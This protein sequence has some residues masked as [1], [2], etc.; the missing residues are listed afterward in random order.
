VARIVSRRDLG[1]PGDVL[2][3]LP[4]STWDAA[5]VDKVREAVVHKNRLWFRYW[6]PTNWAFLAGDRTEQP[7]SRD[8]RDRSIRWF[9]KEM[10]EFVPLIESAD[11]EIR[12]QAMNA[13]ATR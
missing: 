13:E 1:R 10:E 12:R 9:P 2:P 5:A 8:H 4:E 11:A 3:L 6:R 7:S